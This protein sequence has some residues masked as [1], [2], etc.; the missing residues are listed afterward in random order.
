MVEPVFSCVF[1]AVLEYSLISSF[2]Y[3]R[4]LLHHNCFG[5]L[6][7]HL[8]GCLVDYQAARKALPFCYAWIDL[9]VGTN[10]EWLHQ[11]ILNEMLP[12]V[13]LLLDDFPSAISKLSSSLNPRTTEYARNDVTP[14]CQ[15]IYEVYIEKQASHFLFFLLC[16]CDFKGHSHAFK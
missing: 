4:Y 5:K 11:F 15:R 13:I 10:H 7:M 8:F 1:C 6:S 12:T 9:A 16:T 3:C 2:D 14:L